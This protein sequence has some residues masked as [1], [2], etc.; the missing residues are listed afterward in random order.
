MPTEHPCTIIAIDD[1]PLFRKGLADLIAME[2]GLSLLAEAADGGSG[3]ALVQ[4]LR[5][6]LVILDLNMKG[7]D[8]MQTLKAIRS[9]DLDSRVIMMTVS[10]AEQD[11]IAALRAGADGYLLKDMEPEDTLHYL[12]QAAQGHMVVSERLTELLAQALRNERLTPENTGSAGLTEREQQILQ[13]IAQGLSNK[14]IARRLDI[15]EGTVKVHVKHLLKK[16]NLHSRIEA[17][18]WVVN[19]DQARP[20]QK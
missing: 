18:V 4:R 14:L 3:I 20:G 1:H 17:A 13:L 10:D 16:L 15:A 11:V 5:P 19:N 2:P 12:R 6:D 9:A 7:M 8:G